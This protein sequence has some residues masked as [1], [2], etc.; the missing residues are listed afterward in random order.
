MNQDDIDER[1]VAI[2]GRVPVEAGPPDLAPAAARRRRR[3][4]LALVAAPIL[5]L[6]VGATALAGAEVIR[7]VTVSGAGTLDID[8]T[9]AGAG[10]ECMAPPEA[11]AWLAA[12]GYDRVVWETGGT[13]GSG[14]IQV[15]PE[16]SDLPVID[17]GAGGPV[18]SLGALEGSGRESTGG[19]SG[20]T[21]PPE[22]GI[23]FPGPMIDGTLHMIVDTTPGAAR[24]ATCPA[25]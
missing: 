21:T 13:I 18:P 11:A 19:A 4:T 7:L 9:L 17:P 15:G 6:A 1:L 14:T 5:V 12:N 10:L 16:P 25:S 8:D 24:P 23:V 22:D 2:E 3:S 20:S